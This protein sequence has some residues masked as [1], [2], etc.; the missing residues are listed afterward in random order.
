MDTLLTE[1]LGFN[2]S[3]A[4]PNKECS[5][6][7]NSV[8]VGGETTNCEG[9]GNVLVVQDAAGDSTVPKSNADGGSIVITFA[10]PVKLVTDLV[11]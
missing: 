7:G 5:V 11:L 4:S 10:S 2:A 1:S 6:P 3:F 9:L 8:G